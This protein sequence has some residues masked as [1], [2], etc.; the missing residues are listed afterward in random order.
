MMIEGEFRV[1]APLQHTWDF[2]MN[3]NELASSIPS[4]Q[5][6][7]VF[8]D[9]SFAITISQKVGPISA[10]FET[11]T[12]LTEVDP[13][14]RLIARGKG[15]D[16]RMGSSFEFTNHMDLVEIS[17][18]ETLVK[19]KTDVK[20]SGRLASVGQ[21]LIK[22]VAKR[23]VAKAVELIQSRMGGQVNDEI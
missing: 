12:N 16:K 23:E 3:I 18:K 22:I 5:K 9:N 13:P 17:E 15:Q 20:I 21:S 1:Y 6:V 14:N 10:T 4:C 2:L 8:N 7:E 19:Y 11:Q